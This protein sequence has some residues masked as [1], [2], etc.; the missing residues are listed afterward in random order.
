M[1]TLSEQSVC[2]AGSLFYPPHC[3]N[4]GLATRKRRACAKNARGACADHAPFCA[5]C[6]QPFEGMIASEFACSNCERGPL[7]LLLRQRLSEQGALFANSFTGLNTTRRPTSGG[8]WRLGLPSRC[9]TRAS[10]E[11]PFELLVPVPL[12][13]PATAQTPVQPGGGAGALG[14]ETARRPVLNALRRVRK[15]KARRDW[16]GG[17]AWKT[18]A[19]PSNCARMWIVSGRHLIFVDD[20][21]TTGSTIEECARVLKGAGASSVRA[22]TVARG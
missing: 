3:L 7:L 5:V 4:C 16:I 1:L 12:H 15:R 9:W 6:S 10:S 19:T 11:Q 18:C 14:G 8:S 20:V 2:A 17:N 22:I 13:P 21:F